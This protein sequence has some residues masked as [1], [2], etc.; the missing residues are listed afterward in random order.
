MRVRQRSE[1]AEEK[2]GRGEP[3]SVV[4]RIA[5]GLKLSPLTLELV[6]VF[7]RRTTVSSA[8]LRGPRHAAVP[9][10][11]SAVAHNHHLPARLPS[12]PP[13]G[14][15]LAHP[16]RSQSTGNPSEPTHVPPHQLRVLRPRLLL[17]LLATVQERARE[18]LDGLGR[19]RRAERA[20][21]KGR[22]R[23]SGQGGGRRAETGER[24]RR[25]ARERLAQRSESHPWCVHA[26]RELFS[27]EVETDEV[28]KRGRGERGDDDSRRSL[29]GPDVVQ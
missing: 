18:V 17:E 11:S 23:A 12:H 24:R 7:L 20:G 28:D 1:L 21:S 3:R 25:R 8:L 5:N 27:G 15:H 13:Q 10:K 29:G 14:F 22:E 2:D 6:N 26:R 9:A 16:S 4:V 19:G